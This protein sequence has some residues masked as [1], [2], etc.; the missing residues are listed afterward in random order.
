VDL[1]WGWH[2]LLWVLYRWGGTLLLVLTG[3]LLTLASYALL[4]HRTRRQDPALLPLCAPAL[5]LFGLGNLWE[6]RPHLASWLL[7]GSCCWRSRA[8]TT[9]RFPS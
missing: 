8:R 2:V 5:L 4:V 3:I 6:L 7:L 1:L 9:G